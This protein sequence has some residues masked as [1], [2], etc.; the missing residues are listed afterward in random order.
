MLQGSEHP[1]LPDE[2]QLAGFGCGIRVQY[3]ERDTAIVARVPREIDRC[4]GTLADL[5][6]NVVSSS[7]G[8]AQWPD[9]VKADQGVVVIT[10]VYRPARITHYGGRR[11]VTCA[12]WPS[13]GR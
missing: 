3:L 2:S 8:R 13:R 4:E 6:L 5:T 12:A 9:R 7:Q 11:S 10:G 1:D